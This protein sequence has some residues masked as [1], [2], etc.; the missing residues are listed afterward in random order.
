MA[1]SNVPDELNSLFLTAS[2]HVRVIISKLNEEQMLQFY[3]LYKQGTEGPCDKPKPSWYQLTEKQKWEAW[4]SN[5]NLDRESAMTKYISLLDSIDPAWQNALNMESENSWV[6]HSTMKNN[7]KEIA[8]SNKTIFDWVKE[9]NLSKVECFGK[10]Q[11]IK[12]NELCEDG[13][14][15]LH[16]AADRGSLDIVKYL[17]QSLKADINIKDVDGQTPLHYAASCGHSDVVK[18]LLEKGAN[19]NL[20]DNEQQSAFDMANNPQICDL[21]KHFM[22]A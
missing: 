14:S 2:A 19:A 10:L 15:L 11:E 8:D 13:L 6:H 5:K 3:G 4:M 17:I 1:E 20:L 7:D 12:T 9:G 21:L 18:Y 22:Q 16:W